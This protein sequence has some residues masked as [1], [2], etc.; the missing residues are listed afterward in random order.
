MNETQVDEIGFDDVVEAP[1]RG[2][3]PLRHLPE[4]LQEKARKLAPEK[5]YTLLELRDEGEG[6]NASLL[7]VAATCFRMGV[8]YDDTL[9]HLQTAYSPDRIDYESAPRRAVTRVWEADG[10]LAKLTDQ[11]ADGNP[12]AKEECLVR[13]RRT[14]ATLI[15]ESS[16]GHLN[17]S[18][19]DAIGRLFGPDDII[20]MQET[21]LA[22][23]PL[24]KVSDLENF[25]AKHQC[26]L[27][28]FKFLNPAVF[29]KLEGVANPLHPKRKITQRC[30]ENV[31]ARRWVVLEMDSKEDAKL[32][33]FNTFALC[34]AQYAPLVLA[35]DT[36]NKSI[37]F[38]F[39]AD[40]VKPPIRRGFFALACLHGADPRLA[41]K[42]QIARMPNVSSGGEGRGPQKVLYWD[43]R[44]ERIEWDL[45][46]F[47]EFIHK[48]RQ[49]DYFYNSDN[50]KYYTRDNLESW[51]T[52]DRTSVR[53]HL[54]EKGYRDTK[55]E[56]ENVSEVDRVINSFQLD[57][58]VEA[59]L[60]SAS[61]RHA[62]VYEENGHRVI[63]KKSPVFI[64]ARRGEW[65]TVREFLEGL[66]GHEPQQLEIFFGW[67]ADAIRKLRNDGRRRAVWGPA[68]MVH[69]IGPANS[70]KTLLLK[71]ILAP[72]FAD[73]IASA[74]PLFK[75]FPD[76]HN[77]DTF[78]CELLYLDDSPVLEVDYKFRQ[79]FAERI[80]THT[81]GVGG[82]LR[83]MHQ[84]R[85]NV[86]PWWRFIRLMNMEPGTLATLPP[87]DGGVEDKLIYLRGEAMELGPLAEEMKKPGW[88]ERIQKR[89]ADEMPAFLHFLLEEFELPE[90]CKDP[91]HRFP[92]ASFKSNELLEEIAQGSLEN[93]IAH[94]IN[95]EGHANL[96]ETESPFD[97]EGETVLS[98]WEGTADTL[99]DILST[100]GTRASQLRFA[101][102]CPS[103]RVLLSQLRNLEK[104]NPKRFGYSKRL[105]D[106]PNKK[107][108]AEY[109]VLW[110]VDNAFSDD[111]EINELM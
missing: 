100:V 62:G 73:R 35:V 5:A 80:K 98:H 26:G 63:V 21:A 78:G 77:P 74:D 30:N 13:F 49:L 23:G 104:T 71:D 94:R 103:P 34:M 68:Q 86:R 18:A 43:P 4:E 72:A 36:G 38:W 8:S 48:N 12:G 47:S 10:D 76:L 32:E 65:A 19:L 29:K 105:A 37:H 108:G 41:V 40:G 101:K 2:E 91:E 51:V 52:M 44:E 45:K 79:E 3:S 39:D 7:S 25:L 60:Q 54:G 11:D 31:K 50:G 75:R 88:Y 55:L 83:A 46:G 69:I 111:P 70:G 27:D 110:P 96:F 59:V 16:P 6:H 67:L 24:V 106:F 89:I 58:N 57:K 42:S 20:N 53:S 107:K 17:V 92:V 84:G 33:R 93:Y 81:V 64:K 66:L 61:G 99:Y 87:L 28:D 14:P 9:E 1:E 56:G 109:W 90:D 95:N 102:A 82:G 22:A 85:L 97:E 15:A